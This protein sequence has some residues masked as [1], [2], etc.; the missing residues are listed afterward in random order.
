MDY[1]ND[2]PA[3]VGKTPELEQN[4]SGST[5]NNEILE[6][7]E[8]DMPLIE[9]SDITEVIELTD[10]DAP[11]FSDEEEE[12]NVG[13]EAVPGGEM[14][15]MGM[16]VDPEDLSILT[17]TTH[18]DSVYAL[19]VCAARP[20]LLIT[21]GG[22]D[23]AS[24]VKLGPPPPPPPDTP[25][26]TEAGPPL[27]VEASQELLGH[28]DSVTA[29]GFSADGQFAA[30][31]SYD[32]TVKIWDTTTAQLLHSL[33]G[34]GEIDWLAWH[35]KG[36]AVLAGSQDATLWM[37]LAQTGQCMQ[38][39]AGHQDAVT[40]GLFTANGKQ[41]ISGS[42]DCTVK[43]WAPKTG[44][45]KH[46]FSGHGFH[47]APINCM[48]SNNDG[49]L[50]LTGAQDGNI[51]LLSIQTPRVI[52]LIAHDPGA[53]SIMD[54]GD[55]ECCSVETVGFCNTT[56]WIASGGSDK[57]LRIWDISGSAPL[58]RQ[59]CQHGG[60]VIKLVWHQSEPIVFTGCV[61]GQLRAWDART[62]NCMQ[63]FSGHK[64]MIL[65]LGI[66]YADHGKVLLVSAS[67]D[68]TSKFFEFT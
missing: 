62:G 45:C 67:D 1:E 31:G 55:V 56:T 30:T 43:I 32:G 9:E 57:T 40:C 33:E 63:I 17:L 42:A 41:V 34:P 8:D 27:I 2:N 54:Q 48:A 6:D 65:D 59:T 44:A 37:W 5:I 23:K 3:K 61:D 18:T 53:T 58:L 13:M 46:T 14:N 60:S 68:H 15:S 28:T 29:V 20:G 50:L 12:D 51:S 49:A 11:T 38:V 35:T 39:F 4:E 19:G 25:T 64:D 26:P 36:N 21:G 66:L 47:E 24:L 16:E 22:D 7:N 10:Q 52:A